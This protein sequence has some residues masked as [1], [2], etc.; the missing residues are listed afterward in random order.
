ML[1]VLALFRSP[2]LAAQWPL[3]DAAQ[4]ETV[5]RRMM[6][7][8]D[9]GGLAEAWQRLFIGPDPFAAPAW[10]SVYL[11]KESVLFGESLMALRGFLA[12]RG[13]TLDTGLNEPEDHIGLL[14]QLASGFAAQGDDAGLGELLGDHVLPWSGRY[15]EL[16]AA[17]AEQPFYAG[18]AELSAL[19]LAA[20]R[21]RLGVTVVE[22]RLY[23]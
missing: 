12:R 19:T 16:L 7:G 5:R 9:L 8:L 14:L 10:G 11:D 15:L 1:P 23:L 6:E 20:L 17:H 21:E 2:E 22:K 3:G 13:I 4:V 18:L